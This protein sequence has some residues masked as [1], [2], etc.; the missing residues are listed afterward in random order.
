MAL[1]VTITG[2]STAVAPVGPFLAPNGAFYLFGRDATTATT[3][4]AYKSTAPDTSW[5]SVRTQLGFSTAI[6][7]LQG[8]QVGAVIHLLIQHGT[9]SSAVATNWI[10][11]NTA[12]DT[13]ATSEAVSTGVAVTGQVASGWGCSLVVRANGE[14][15]AFYNGVQTKT[16]GTFR[17]RVYYRR[18]TAVNTWSTE[19]QVDSNTAVDNTSP[20]AVLGAADRVHFFWSTGATNTGFRTLSAANALNT[21]GTTANANPPGDGVSYD[22]SGTTKVIVRGG[23]TEVV[24]NL[25]SSDNPTVTPVAVSSATNSSHPHRIGVDTETD[26]VTIVYRNTAD[27]D[28]YAVKSTDDGATWGAAVSFFV[29]TVGNTDA[30]VSRSSSGSMYGRGANFVV[31]YIVND[32]GTLKYNE[33]T[34]R[35]NVSSLVGTASGVGASSVVGA[36]TAADTVTAAGVGGSSVKGETVVGKTVTA[37]GVGG[38]SVVGETVVAAVGSRILISWV[39]VRGTT[40]RTLTSTAVSGGIGTGAA[41][42]AP[43]NRIAVSW[44]EI[45]G[46]EQDAVV[47]APA[48][49]WGDTGGLIALSN[50]NL[51][52]LGTSP[53]GWGSTRASLAHTTGKWYC[54]IEV[55]PDHLDGIYIGFGVMDDSTPAGGGLDTY[56][57][58]K[59]GGTRNDGYD[60]INGFSGGTSYGLGSVVA[61]ATRIGLAINCDT[62]ELFFSNN[63]VWFGD[64]VAGTGSRC[65]WHG[66]AGINIYPC[67]MLFFAAARIHARASSQLYSAPSGYSAW[68]GVITATTDATAA[69]AG[70]GATAFAGTAIKSAT[71]TATATSAAASTGSSF[72]A[73]TG[74]ATGAGA[75]TITGQA[76]AGRTVTAGGVGASNIVNRSFYA[77]IGLSSGIGAGG[78][79]GAYIFGVAVTAAGIGGSS[80]VGGQLG[81]NVLIGSGLGTSAVVGASTAATNGVAAGVGASSVKGSDVRP[82]SSVAAGLGAGTATGFS[83]AASASSAA[84]TSTA[85][86]TGNALLARTVTAAGTGASSF[87]GGQLGVNVFIGAGLGVAT[88]SGASTA[89]TVGTAAGVGSTTVLGTNVKH[90]V[91]AAAGLGAGTVTGFSFVARTVSTAGVGATSITGLAIFAGKATAAGTGASAVQGGQ[92]GVNVLIGAGLG[93]GAAIGASTAATTATAAGLG[94]ATAPGT[95]VKPASATAAGLAAGTVTGRS[96]A[97]GTGSAVGTGTASSTGI[98]VAARTVT[99]AGVGGSAV[100]GGQLGVNVAAAAGI[101]AANFVGGS[102]AAGIAAAAG[103]GAAPWTGAIIR[104]AGATATGAGTSAVT[105]RAIVAGVATASGTGASAFVAQVTLSAVNLVAPL[106]VFE[107]PAVSLPSS[108]RLGDRVLDYGLRTLDLEADKIFICNNFPTTYLEATSTYAVGSKH[109]GQGLVFGAPAAGAPKGRIVTSIAVSDGLATTIGTP[110]CW[111][112]VDS[113]NSRLLAT[114]PASG[115]TTVGVNWSWTLEQIPIHMDG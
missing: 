8:Y 54:E 52:A 37:S 45:E 91:A 55:L 11:F 27:S 112:V 79:T 21:A 58:Y 59:C 30:A 32:N 63:G 15:V 38:S 43:V 106:P 66:Q 100:T 28:L 107:N 61:G 85:A 102:T 16:S 2:I 110:Q 86:A 10:S 24:L 74:T 114:G 9:I 92:L 103:V 99:A 22:R 42:S 94:A 109:F 76:V 75:T 40:G 81:V 35:A 51:D 65:N 89:A 113:M 41:I 18:R 34:I 36:S 77:T 23:S 53:S 95:N 57:P 33:Y 14:A 31:G 71:A 62:Q 39:E 88:A 25:N 98:A 26:D 47:S 56:A 69:A 60:F 19:T 82:T 49:T 84:G 72:A 17:A 93:T 90:T 4:Q 20:L 29:G 12:T 83:F 73:G 87:A 5:A 1:P 48:F 80:V 108:L 13:F 3:L 7:V 67:A 46:V 97:A 101:G 105:G 44:V 111:A 104:L 96:F 50:G 70:V 6:A 115:F 78:A 64:P 68:A